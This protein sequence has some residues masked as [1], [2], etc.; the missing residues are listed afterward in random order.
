MPRLGASREPVLSLLALFR[1]A[2]LGILLTLEGETCR[3]YQDYLFPV[4]QAT[5][6]SAGAGR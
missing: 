1:E 5:D 3:G 2:M 6:L 4:L